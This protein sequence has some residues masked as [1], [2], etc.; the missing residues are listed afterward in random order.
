M[1]KLV[2][3]TAVASITCALPALAQDG[4]QGGGNAL[5]ARPAATLAQL[6]VCIG[7][8]CPRASRLRSILRS[9]R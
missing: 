9:L 6:D 8:D 4:V 2:L 1:R 7:P 3:I 5:P